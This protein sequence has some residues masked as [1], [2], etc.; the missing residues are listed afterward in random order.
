M[1]SWQIRTLLSSEQPEFFSQSSCFHIPAIHIYYSCWIFQLQAVAANT[2]FPFFL[3]TLKIAQLRS[4]CWTSHSHIVLSHTVSDMHRHST[5]QYNA[6]HFILNRRYLKVQQFLTL[7][8]YQYKMLN[9]LR[10]PRKQFRNFCNQ[11]SAA[12]RH[13]LIFTDTTFLTR[14][15]FSFYSPDFFFF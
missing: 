4:I 13:I 2:T 7:Y 6:R 11:Q 12:S 5:H 9:H 14:H 1:S 8:P 15:N 10:T 3:S